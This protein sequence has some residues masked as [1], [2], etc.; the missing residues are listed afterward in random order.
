MFG[1]YGCSIDLLPNSYSSAEKA[2]AVFGDYGCSIDLLPNS[3][4]S[5]EK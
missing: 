3:Y 4:S 2:I 5:A 1:D